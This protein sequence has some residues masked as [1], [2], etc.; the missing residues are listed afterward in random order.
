MYR[1]GQTETVLEPIY[2]GE[3]HVLAKL[4]RYPGRDAAASDQGVGAHK[5][6]EL[7]SLLRQDAQQGVQVETAQGWVNVTPHAGTL[8]VNIRQLLELAS[9][10]YLCATL[11]RVVT[12]PAGSE[13]ISVAFLL[14]ARLDSTGPLAA[15]T[16]RAGAGHGAR[17]EE[18]PCSV[19]SDRT[20]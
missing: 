10:G 11:Y 4:I 9:D 12:P 6:A 1:G 8:A 14:G 19:T 20:T 16:G 15:G 7:L 17:S 5:N 13:R 3:P 2:G 18:P